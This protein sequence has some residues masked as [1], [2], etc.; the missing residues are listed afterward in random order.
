MGYDVPWFD[1]RKQ[2]AMNPFDHAGGLCWSDWPDM[3]PAS[4]IAAMAD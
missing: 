2:P 3:G 4:L 1:R